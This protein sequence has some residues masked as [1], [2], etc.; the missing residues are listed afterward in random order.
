MMTNISNT[1][2][3]SFSY[4]MNCSLSLLFCTQILAVIKVSILRSMNILPKF[5]SMQLLLMLLFNVLFHFLN[6]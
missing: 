4:V 3:I 5:L 6:I 1:K 2:G